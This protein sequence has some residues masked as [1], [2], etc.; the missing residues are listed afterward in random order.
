MFVFR[1]AKTLCMIHAGLAL[2]FAVLFFVN[3][4]RVKMADAV[5]QPSAQV[6]IIK[7]RIIDVRKEDTIQIIFPTVK[8]YVDFEFSYNGQTQQ[9]TFRCRH[10]SACYWLKPGPADIIVAENG[11]YA[12]PLDL[13]D[14]FQVYRK[15][16]NRNLKGSLIMALVL[17]VMASI[18]GISAGII[19]LPVRL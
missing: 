2:V 13:R 16:V 11:R 19:R 18:S 8:Q 3:G 10:M 5:S 1:D 15:R 12:L 14:N 9:Q 17:S 7:G 6:E 4:S